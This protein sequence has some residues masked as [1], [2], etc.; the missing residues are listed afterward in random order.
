VPEICIEVLSD[1]N[2]E[3]EMEAK[4]RLFFEG[5]AEEVWIVGPGGELRSFDPA[6][7]RERSALAP[8]FPERI[9]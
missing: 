7:E 8:T 3:A 1:S 5:G 4:R 9:V 2:A 6:G